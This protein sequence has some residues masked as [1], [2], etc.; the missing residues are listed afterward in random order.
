MME[1][2]QK[3][4]L[5]RA[6]WYASRLRAMHP[7]EIGLRTR[8][9]LSARLDAAAR[10]LA[11]PLWRRAWY[12]SGSRLHTSPSL[13]RPLGFLEAERTAL[14]ARER[15]DSVAAIVEH[16]KRLLSGR[17]ALLGYPEVTLWTPPTGR[18]IRSPASRGRTDTA[19]CW[20]TGGRSTATPSGSGS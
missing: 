9:E 3:T 4:R 12:P 5:H 1:L 18:T 20:T 19:S 15:P 7:A 13:D 2:V 16:G 11:P 17:T 6:V 8:R 10:R 14:L